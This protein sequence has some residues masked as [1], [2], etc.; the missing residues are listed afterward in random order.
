M[1]LVFFSCFLQPLLNTERLDVMGTGSI[2]KVK[3]QMKSLISSATME[4]PCLQAEVK[5]GRYLNRESI[6]LLSH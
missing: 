3:R 2:K 1:V 6:H 5:K 4:K